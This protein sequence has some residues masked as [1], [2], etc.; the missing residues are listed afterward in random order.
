MSNATANTRVEREAR[1]RWVPI[2][3]MAVSPLAQREINQSRVDHIVATFDLEQIGAP[4]VNKRDGAWYVLDGQHRVEALRAIGWGDQQIQCWA[5]E[6]LTEQEEAEKFLKLNDY[7]AVNALAKFRV[8]VQAG[9]P[10]ECDIDRI[11]RACGLVITG[12]KVPGGIAAV[13]T[14]RRVYSRAGAGTLRQTLAIVRDAYGDAGLEAAVLDGIALFVQRYASDLDVGQVVT[15]LSGASGGVHGLLG[16]AEILRRQT[17]NQKGHCVAAAAVEIV[18]SG[19][20][21]KKL[22]GWWR[23]D[24]GLRAVSA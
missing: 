19:K 18:N 17:G 22:V 15:K 14:L 4:T 1:L 16:K 20:G 5:Y 3:L 21:G 8:G 10:D 2:S 7:L 12:D 11:V 23:E 9:R 6:G 24:T 13:G